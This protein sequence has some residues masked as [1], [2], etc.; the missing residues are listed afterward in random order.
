MYCISSRVELTRGCPPAWVLGEELTAHRRRKAACYEMLHGF[1][2]GRMP[3]N[4]LGNG[5]WV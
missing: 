2:L 1:G 5:K 3:W 4:D